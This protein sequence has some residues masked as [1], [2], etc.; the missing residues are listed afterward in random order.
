MRRL[1]SK[2]K[3]EKIRV[4]LMRLNGRFLISILYVAGSVSVCYIQQLQFRYI[5]TDKKHCIADLLGSLSGTK[6]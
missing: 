5:I 2:K 1:I 3:Q 6:Y 4:G